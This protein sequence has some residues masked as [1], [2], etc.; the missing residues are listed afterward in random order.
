VSDKDRILSLEKQLAGLRS[1]NTAVS[2]V[3]NAVTAQPLK[4]ADFDKEKLIRM[5]V[6]AVPVEEKT[7]AI[8]QVLIGLHKID[9]MIILQTLILQ[10]QEDMVATA[11]EKTGDKTIKA[12]E[13]LLVDSA[14]LNGQ[15][16]LLK[17]MSLQA[18]DAKK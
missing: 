5:A 15:F 13:K 3:A 7:Q 11:K 8:K 12:A 10:F 2:T 16:L 4:E 9:C 17:G 18:I 1:L 14:N 6:D